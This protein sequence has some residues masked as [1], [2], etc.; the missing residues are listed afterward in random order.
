MQDD[1]FLSGLATLKNHPSLVEIFYRD[2]NEV[3]MHNNEKRLKATCEKITP[4]LAENYKV[5]TLNVIWQI[6][7]NAGIETFPES[8]MEEIRI[9]PTLKMSLYGRKPSKPCFNA[10]DS[11]QNK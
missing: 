9:R 11:F 7:F 4:L 5:V 2:T 8:A 3:S 10:T 1:D 6:D